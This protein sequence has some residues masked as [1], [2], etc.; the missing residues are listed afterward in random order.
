MS[1]SN[2][3]VV[4]TGVGIVSPI[5]IGLDSFWENLSG[6]QS[7]ISAIERLSD[8]ALPQNVG[9][10][11]K[12]FTD[13]TAKKVYLKKQRK[14]IKIMCREIQLGV[15]SA[16]LALEHSGLDPEQIDHTRLGIEFG[17]NQML[18]P[19]DVLKDAVGA[20]VE[21]ETF[22]YGR[23]GADGLGGMEPL[24]LL[25]YLPNMPACHIAIFADARGPNNSLTHAEA[26]GN[27]ALGEAYRVIVRGSADM[28]I[29][30][31]TGSRID[32][33]KGL[34]AA[35]WDQLASSG[36][37]PATWS[38]PFDRDRMG[39]VVGEGACSFI[40]ESEEHAKARG[41]DILGEIL[42]TGSSCVMNRD[43]QANIEAAMVNAI[44]S[45]LNAA[46]VTTEDIGHINAHGLGEKNADA[47]EA[48][49]IH[50]V[51]GDRATS[52]PVTALK[53]YIGNSGSGCGT[54]ELAGSLL[55]LKHGIVA[56][57]L[58]YSNP[59]PECELNVV[60]NEPLAV[61]NKTVLNINVNSAGQASALVACGV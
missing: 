24:W 21:E 16:S 45:A 54:L 23:W 31:T 56:P 28:M 11:V 5:G 20:C 2:R 12:E 43:G 10:E 18:S 52:V 30:G 40:I 47:R 57:T 55:G 8:T 19:P 32:P 17:A 27:L 42:G 26:S 7:G 36:E 13:S 53:S 1:E 14:S 61:N 46:G 6:G 59:D 49:A 3:R 25:K 37:D 39:Q 15:A 29:A 60:H 34:H 48:A 33:T 35:L 51:F 58:N 9:G 22:N 41:A 4:V 50:A 44:R 38:R